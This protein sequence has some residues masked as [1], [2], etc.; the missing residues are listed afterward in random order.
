[1][2]DFFF[3][4]EYN[5]CYKWDEII[6]KWGEN[7]NDQK[8]RISLLFNFFLLTSCT[9]RNDELSGIWYAARKN[10][11]WGFGKAIWESE[12]SDKILDDINMYYADDYYWVTE[13]GKIDDKM[14]V[15]VLKRNIINYTNR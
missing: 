13:N 10:R 5:C 8:N 12:V 7:F 14:E 2:V 1:M 15:L 4:H 9:T 11:E 3:A 6:L